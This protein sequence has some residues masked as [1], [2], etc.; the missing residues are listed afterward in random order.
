MATSGPPHGTPNGQSIRV[1]PELT[2]WARLSDLIRNHDKERIEDVKEDV[3]TLLVFVSRLT[4]SRYTL[5][6][7]PYDQ[8]G[9]FS[10]VITAFVLES[11][12]NLQS[13][14]DDTTAQI[15]QQITIQLSSLTISGGFLNSTLQPISPSVFSVRPPAILVNTLWSLSLVIALMTASLGILVKQWFHEFMAR[16]TQDPRELV[17]TRFFRDIG[18]RNWHVFELASFLPFL[19]QL[20]LLLF[21]V[22]LGFFLL[23]LNPIVGWITTGAMSVWLV[24]FIFTTISPIFSSQCP[25]KTPILKGLLQ[26]IRTLMY[27]SILFLLPK[28][29]CRLSL[30]SSHRWWNHPSHTLYCWVEAWAVS[31]KANEEKNIRVAKGLDHQILACVAETL[32][33]ERLTE[34]L[35]QCIQ[36]FDGEDMIKCAQDLAEQDNEEMVPAT[37]SGATEKDVPDIIL[38]MVVEDQHP[39]MQLDHGNH[40]FVFKHLYDGLMFALLRRYTPWVNYPI[41]LPLVPKFS[42]MIR[43]GSTKAV[44]AVLVMY[45]IRYQTIERYPDEWNHLFLCPNT[46]LYRIGRSSYFHIAKLILRRTF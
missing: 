30:P 23:G 18:M 46:V 19:L 1:E 25:Y 12:K 14:A 15:L 11:Y 3:D 40:P 29:A 22:G 21:Y 17:K 41:P 28:C 35:S 45:S 38:N 2:G 32:R 37:I 10:A 33:G 34:T 16:D 42:D 5:V 9:L 6:L 4:P 13:Q 43:G 39:V 8:A 7:H 20:A 36:E 31:C 27:S 24:V 26:S 44:F